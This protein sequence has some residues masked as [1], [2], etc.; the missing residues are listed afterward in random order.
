MRLLVRSSRGVRLTE[1]GSAFLRG[2]RASLDHS[3]RAVLEA[4]RAASGEEGRVQAG[5]VGSA[6]H[7]VLTGIAGPFG[8]RAPAPR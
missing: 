2:A 3:E 8:D 6:A 5:L 4:R 1:A 7:G